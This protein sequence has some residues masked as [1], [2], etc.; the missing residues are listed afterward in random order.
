MKTYRWFQNLG[1]GNAK[2]IFIKGK[3]YIYNFPLKKPV[4]FNWN[5]QSSFPFSSVRFGLK[6]NVFSGRVSKTVQPKSI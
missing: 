1:L 2:H 4:T 5:R 3:L 6:P